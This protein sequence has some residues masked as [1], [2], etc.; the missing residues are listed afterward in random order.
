MLKA[1]KKP[2][3]HTFAE[4]YLLS[5]P[6]PH[7]NSFPAPLISSNFPILFY[8]FFKSRTPFLIFCLFSLVYFY[9]PFPP[10]PPIT[11]NNFSHFEIEYFLLRNITLPRVSLY[12]RIVLH[13]LLCT[14]AIMYLS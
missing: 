6:T 10:P 4:C 9:F 14:Y 11:C 5:L 2:Y 3:Q 12:S 1:N 8:F 13:R 7:P